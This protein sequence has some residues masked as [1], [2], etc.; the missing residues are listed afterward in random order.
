[1]PYQPTRYPY[2]ISYGRPS[3]NT[4]FSNATQYTLASNVTPNIDYG[5]VFIAASGMTITDFTSG[6]GHEFGRIIYIKA[7]TNGVIL[8]N[9]A[10]GI[11]FNNIIGTTSA[12]STVA[13]T[14][15]GNLTMLNG[16]V[17]G[18]IDDGTSWCL[19]GSRFA[20]STQV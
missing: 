4:A 9:S 14:T 1:M 8:Q 17:L 6:I 5:T 15:A 10:G 7:T 18:F 20:L 16:E 12:G 3:A 11:R 2:G 19:V 13:F